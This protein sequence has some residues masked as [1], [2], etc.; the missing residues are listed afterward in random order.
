[1]GFRPWGA[2]GRGYVPAME[3][4]GRAGYTRSSLLSLPPQA[5][6]WL[7]QDPA[8]HFSFLSARCGPPEH[9]GFRPHR[10]ADPPIPNT[11]HLPTSG[12]LLQ[13]GP[14]ACSS[15]LSLPAHPAWAPLQ[16]SAPSLLGEAVSLR[17]DVYPRSICSSLCEARQPSA[18]LARSSSAPLPTSSD[19]KGRGFLRA[20]PRVM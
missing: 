16:C 18:L 6:V 13:R 4:A 10:P 1:M 3:G 7:R 17:R 15:L 9:P 11:S 20:G 14:S 12:P 2:G 8:N 19:P 5:L